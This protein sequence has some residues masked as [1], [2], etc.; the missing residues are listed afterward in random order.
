MDKS[1]SSLM[2]LLKDMSIRCQDI[3]ELL[4]LDKLYFSNNNLNGLEESNIKKVDAINQLSI[5]AQELKSNVDIDKLTSP[6]L[7]NSVANLKS[8][9]AA[10]YDLI[11]TNN[12]IV[13]TNMQQLKE[14]WD[15]VVQQTS[16]DTVYDHTGSTQK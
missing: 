13:F 3:R 15:R 10:C 11:V 7:Q 16:T 9:I 6:E 1:I 12:D 2:H 4:S 5:L 14:I 8:E